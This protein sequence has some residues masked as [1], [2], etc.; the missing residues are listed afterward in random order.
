MDNNASIWNQA[1]STLPEPHLLQTWDWARIKAGAGWKSIPLA[2]AQDGTLLAVGEL[3]GR[4]ISAAA[5]VLQRGLPIRSFSARLC[6]QYVARGPLLDWENEPLRHRVLDDLRSLARQSGAIFIKIDP[7]V[8]VGLGVPG[9]PGSGEDPTGQQVLKDLS[10]RGWKFSSEQIQFRNTVWVDLQP[11]E[12][13][14]LAR[15]KQK[16]RYNVRLAERKG[17][18]VRLGSQADF[19]M[20]YHMYAETSQRDGFVIREERYYQ[21]IWKTFLENLSANPE[22]CLPAGQPLIAEVDAE[23]VAAVIPV[24]FAGKAWYL[25]GMSREMYR[26]MMPNYL[27][28]WEAMRWAKR[29]GCSTYD[30]WGAP[31]EF[32]QNDSMWGVY[33][34]KEGLGGKVIRTIG[35]WDLPVQPLFYRLYTQTLPW[36]LSVMRRRGRQRTKQMLAG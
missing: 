28:Q 27:L 11:S 24:R 1:I 36:L 8:L 26:E 32:N 5:M 31:D 19:D 4:K 30:L 34:F 33:R 14:I 25:Y 2:W 15:M 13:E 7:N 18:K 22:E 29:A 12:D 23:A 6:I 9:E 3:E 10:E 17:V 21:G 20:L 35:A 16:T